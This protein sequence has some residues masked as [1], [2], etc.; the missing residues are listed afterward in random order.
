MFLVA[1]RGSRAELSYELTRYPERWE[2]FVQYTH[3]Q[4]EELMCNY[5]PVDIL[6]LDGGWVQKLT[7]EELVEMNADPMYRFQQLQSQD[8]RMDELAAMARRHQP[9]LIVV[10]R[11][12]PGPNQNYLTPENRVP[13]RELPYPWESCIISGGGWSFTP[14][15][16]YMSVRDG[17]HMLVDIVA[18]G[19]NLLFNVAPGPDGRWQE[20]AYELLAGMGEWI[21]V[22][23]TAIYGSK[24]RAPYKRDGVCVV[25]G[26]DGAVY[27][28]VLPGEGENA[29]PAEVVVPGVTPPAGAVIRMLGDDRALVWTV[30]GDDLVVEIPAA[31]RAALP[32]DHAWGLRI[33]D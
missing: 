4:I 17:V 12:V 8:I 14:D 24:A 3:A 2:R 19:G 18:K 13:E 16:Q 6:W 20:G 7:D 31:L 30:R 25:N 27:A 26:A 22:N 29:P 9:G 1:F 11:A 33:P 15:A 32:C 28:V 23:G 5:G 21:E 10:D